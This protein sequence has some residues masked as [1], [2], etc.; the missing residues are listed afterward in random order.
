MVVVVDDGGVGGDGHG[1]HGGYSDVGVS[2]VDVGVRIH[3]TQN[4]TGNVRIV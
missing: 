2:V 4:K 3:P 1:G